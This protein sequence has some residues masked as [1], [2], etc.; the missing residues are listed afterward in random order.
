[1]SV[2]WILTPH[3]VYDLLR[4]PLIRWGAVHP[5]G[6]VFQGTEVA[7]VDVVQLISIYFCRLCFGVK[8]KKSSAN[9][10]SWSISP[11]ISSKSFLVLLPLDL[12][13]RSLMHFEIIYMM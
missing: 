11:M 6:Y 5:F 1:M 4:S 2:F 8:S 3:Q 10:M 13:F 9:P 12:L 7:S